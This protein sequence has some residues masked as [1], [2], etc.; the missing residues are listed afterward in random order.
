[1]LFRE[2]FTIKKYFM[3]SSITSIIPS[4]CG[5]LL[6]RQFYGIWLMLSFAILNFLSIFWFLNFWHF[7]YISNYLQI[8]G[9]KCKTYQQNFN[10]SLFKVWVTIFPSRSR[11]PSSVPAGNCSSNWTEVALFSTYPRPDHPPRIVVIQLKINKTY[12]LSLIRLNISNLTQ[13]NL[14]WPELGTA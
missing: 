5:E 11:R 6:P 13:L 14:T 9:D 4:I 1:M 12:F 10:Y 8:K 2:G 3:E 7:T